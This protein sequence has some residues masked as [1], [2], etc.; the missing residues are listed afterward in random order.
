M[1]FTPELF[2]FLADLT[3]NNDREWFKANKERYERDIKA[4]SLAFI[5]AFEP[6]LHD[7]SPHFEAIAKA[8]GGSLFRIYRDT[9]FS[10]D[11]TPYKTHVGLHFKHE[12]AKDVHAPGFYLH[13]EPGESGGGY[14][15]WMPDNPTLKRIRDRIVAEPDR[16]AAVK[17]ALTEAGGSLHEGGLKRPPRGYDKDHPH[18]EDLKR[19]SFA[20]M[21]PVADHDVLGD[22]AP[23]RFAALCEKGAPLVEFVCDALDVAY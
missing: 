9:R 1:S 6:Y 10:K 17:A 4:P 18:I 7:L 12:R 8:S 3:A 11:K 20:A 19:K 14:G 2:T 15:V 13:I 21:F 23:A 22:D 16:W 5:T